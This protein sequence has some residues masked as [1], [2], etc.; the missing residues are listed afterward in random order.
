MLYCACKP[1]RG[2]A[3]NGLRNFKFHNVVF[4]NVS[5]NHAE[6]LNSLSSISDAL[7]NHFFT[8]LGLQQSL[9]E[10]RGIGT[11][12]YQDGLERGSES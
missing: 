3:C 4:A 11:F 8:P 9:I 12:S 1:N 10:F 2:V 7:E 6:F 5:S